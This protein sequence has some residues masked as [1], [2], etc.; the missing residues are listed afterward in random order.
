M[1]LDEF[2]YDPL[3]RAVRGSY[4]LT[5]F[6]PLDEFRHR[7]TALPA[8]ERAWYQVLLVG[9]P[10]SAE[11][12]SRAFGR[13]MTDDLVATGLLRQRGSRLGTPGLGLV[14][15]EGNYAVSSLDR[16]YPGGLWQRRAWVGVDSFLLA[17][18]LP[19]TRRARSS[20]DLGCGSGLLSVLLAST[21][22]RVLAVDVDPLAT[23]VATFNAA[24]NDLGSLEV[25]TGDLFEPVGSE[26]FD[27]VVA[28]PP[29]VPTLPHQAGSTAV[30]GGPDGL[31]LVR[32]LLDQ[33]ATHLTEEGQA[34]IY[35]EG[36]GDRDRPLVMEALE[37]V[38]KRDA[39]ATDVLVLSRVPIGRAA[40]AL[41]RGR[42]VSLAAYRRLFR[43]HGADRYY[44]LILRVRRGEGGLRL[45]DA[46]RYA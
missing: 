34:I 29:M 25:R 4:P 38:A 35:Q 3:L 13:E 14:T 43:E 16:S 27:L 40:I 1:A 30:D 45:L 18:F 11:R 19:R 12:I 24:L 22:R 44:K 33:L 6:P 7:L 41:A 10:M 17:H 23:S 9:M 28:N 42:G 37:G 46:G 21:S 8:R 5:P 39:L 20:L 31:A 26:A 15:M 32:R 36:I 2:G